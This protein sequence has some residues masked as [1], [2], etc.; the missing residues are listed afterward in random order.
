V[1][2]GSTLG[3]LLIYV[4]ARWMLG[5]FQRAAPLLLWATV[6]FFVFG[7]YS[8]PGLEATA[9]VSYAVI[10]A[11]AST[12][13]A[14]RHGV[15]A[16]VTFQFLQ[17]ASIMTIFTLDPTAWYFP[18]T[19]IFLLIVVVMTIFGIRTSADRKLLPSRS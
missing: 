7:A 8:R 17:Q 2:L 3:F 16:L 1:T 9:A 6:F 12:Y 19:A 10:S 15:L 11:T 4:V 18:P 14:V 5:R 13:L